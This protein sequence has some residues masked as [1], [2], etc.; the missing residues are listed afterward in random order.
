[1]KLFS[2]TFFLSP[3]LVIL[4]LNKHKRSWGGGESAID[5][6]FFSFSS[7]GDGVGGISLPQNC[8]P[9]EI[10]VFSS[11]YVTIY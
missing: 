9:Q 3:F 6:R 8:L 7:F 4:M 5:V 2:H 11:S 1:M 10:L